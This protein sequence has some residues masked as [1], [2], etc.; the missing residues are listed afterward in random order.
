MENESM[1]LKA[2]REKI[3]MTAHNCPRSEQA[4]HL[5]SGNSVAKVEGARIFN[6][7]FGIY[8][9][10]DILADKAYFPII[11]T[12][13]GG[14]FTAHNEAELNEWIDAYCPMCYFCEDLEEKVEKMEGKDYQE[15][16][17][18]EVSHPERLVYDELYDFTNDEFYGYKYVEI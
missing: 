2:F 13:G 14:R 16:R 9:K 12:H 5:I 6:V 1:S 7:R 11:F 8:F 18:D 17:K 3:G 4:L 10:Y 15:I